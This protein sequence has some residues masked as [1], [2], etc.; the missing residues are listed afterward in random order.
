MKDGNDKG[1]VTVALPQLPLPD[2]HE[3]IVVIMDHPQGAP[4]VLADEC[5][6]TITVR[7][8]LGLFFVSKVFFDVIIIG[9]G[10]SFY[11]FINFPAHFV[12]L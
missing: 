10:Q 2:Q 9:N 1:I 7:N 5:I 8:D 4:A 12:K 3:T 6:S 11:N